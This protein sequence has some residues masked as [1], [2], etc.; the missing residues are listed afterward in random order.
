[1]PESELTPIFDR[2]TARSAVDGNRMSAEERLPETAYQI[3]HD[4]TM[5]DGN[6]R[7]NLATFV[8]TWMDDY[9]N[10]LYAEM[11]D[12]NM[13]DKDEYPSTAAVEEHCWKII[14]ALA[15]KMPIR[16]AMSLMPVSIAMS[17]IMIDEEREYSAQ[18]K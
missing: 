16:A 7:L 8:S 15:A 10:R 17:T 12:K 3:V 6:A 9:A 13:I 18:R 1:M 2:S 4:E 14:A 11:F 5:L